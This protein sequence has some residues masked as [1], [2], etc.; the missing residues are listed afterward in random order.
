MTRRRNHRTKMRKLLTKKT[1]RA[2]SLRRAPQLPSQKSTSK[3]MTTATTCSTTRCRQIVSDQWWQTCQDSRRKP[4][5]RWH[6][7]QRTKWKEIWMKKIGSW[8]KEAKRKAEEFERRC[9]QSSRVSVEITKK[10]R[11]ASEAMPLTQWSTNSH[12]SDFKNS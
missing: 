6:A 8:M 9:K 4:R 5:A 12:M 3:N 2:A 10:K 7:L 11:K 1:A